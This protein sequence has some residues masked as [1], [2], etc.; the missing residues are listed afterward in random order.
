M[1]VSHR[2]AR[3][4]TALK[5]LISEANLFAPGKRDQANTS[6]LAKLWS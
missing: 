1:K 6:I 2:T 5:N 4:W 3:N